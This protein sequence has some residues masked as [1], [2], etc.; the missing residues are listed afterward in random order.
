[1]SQQAHCMYKC[2]LLCNCDIDL[3]RKSA[4][5]VQYAL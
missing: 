3:M 5:D 2:N 4:A 1:M